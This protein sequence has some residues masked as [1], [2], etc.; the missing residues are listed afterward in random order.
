MVKKEKKN[1][2]SKIVY[3]FEITLLDGE[4]KLDFKKKSLIK[5]KKKGKTGVKCKKKKKYLLGHPHSSQ[6]VEYYQKVGRTHH[7]PKWT[8]RSLPLNKEKKAKEGHKR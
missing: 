6:L 4:S 3:L 1:K 7:H 2:K 8:Q 5:K